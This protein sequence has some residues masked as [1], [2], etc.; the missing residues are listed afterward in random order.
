MLLTRTRLNFCEGL[1]F[2]VLCYLLREKSVKFNP[3]LHSPFSTM[4]SMQSVSKNPLIATFQ[5]SSASS[6]NL[7]QSQ[8]GILGNGL[9]NFRQ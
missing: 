4:F 1:N 2:K 7:G 8:N 6:L 5:L 3:F 9:K